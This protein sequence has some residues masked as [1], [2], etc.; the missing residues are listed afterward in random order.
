MNLR[1]R[2][3]P[4]EEKFI[5]KNEFVEDEELEEFNASLEL[6]Q[7]IEIRKELEQE[8]NQSR[9]ENQNL[10]ETIKKLI[11]EKESIKD[12]FIPIGLLDK[13]IEANKLNENSLQLAK[14]ELIETQNR[15]QQKTDG[16]ASVIEIFKA[17]IINAHLEGM[18]SLFKKPLEYVLDIYELK[19]IREQKRSDE[20][21]PKQEILSNPEID[22]EAEDYIKSEMCIC[23]KP[24][25]YGSKGCSNCKKQVDKIRKRHGI[26]MEEAWKKLGEDEI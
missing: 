2:N 13:Q 6:K 9:T 11:V 18:K 1:I 24:K 3:P 8:V 16:E 5:E 19:N 4:E 15:L 21:F 20:E 23:G 7:E 10:K 22:S 25:F 12:N 14:E 26:S 17:H